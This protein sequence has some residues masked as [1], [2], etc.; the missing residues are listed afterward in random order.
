MN[1]LE[2]MANLQHALYDALWKLW[3]DC[4]NIDHACVHYTPVYSYISNP[5]NP[6]I[7][8]GRLG[9]S[10]CRNCEGNDTAQGYNHYAQ[11]GLYIIHSKA[12]E[13]LGPS[14]TD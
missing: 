11:Y 4:L 9:T 2:N 13:A 6:I 5:G 8:T 7:V 1:E 12:M 14:I 3:V 10:L